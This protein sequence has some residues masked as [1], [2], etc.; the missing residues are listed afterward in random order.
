MALCGL[1]RALSNSV[2]IRFRS[3]DLPGLSN[4]GGSNPEFSEGLGGSEINA[5]RCQGTCWPLRAPQRVQ[6]QRALRTTFVGPTKV[7]ESSRR[8]LEFHT[9]SQAKCRLVESL[10]PLLVPLSPASESP[11]AGTY[12]AMGPTPAFRAPTSTLGTHDSLYMVLSGF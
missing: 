9:D 5:G 12:G 2:E 7:S 6:I 11:N 4:I 1:L 8:L 3:T 10:Y